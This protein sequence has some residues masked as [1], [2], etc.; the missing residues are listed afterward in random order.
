MQAPNPKLAP[1]NSEK[2]N[3]KLR[4]RRDFAFVLKGRGYKRAVV[5]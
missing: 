5:R 1:R 4:K 2:A 3:Q